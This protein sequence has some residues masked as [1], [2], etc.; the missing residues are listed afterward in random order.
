VEGTIRTYAI[1]TREFGELPD[2][3]NAIRSRKLTGKTVLTL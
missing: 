1:E 3:L 2:I